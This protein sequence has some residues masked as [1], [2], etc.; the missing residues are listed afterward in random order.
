MCLFLQQDIKWMH[1]SISW[2]VHRL[3]KGNMFCLK[4]F[5]FG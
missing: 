2:D 5:F 1:V 3:H 4:G